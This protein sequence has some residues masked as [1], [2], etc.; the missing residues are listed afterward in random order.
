[1]NTSSSSGFL[2]PSKFKFMRYDKTLPRTREYTCQNKSC[3]T[4]KV[5]EKKSA[6]WFR[7][8]LDSYVTY[9]VCEECGENWNTALNE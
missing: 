8:E 4:H 5:P 1:M 3:T 6:A 2:D 9:Y 7:P